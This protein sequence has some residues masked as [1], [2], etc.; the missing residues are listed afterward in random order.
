MAP[1]SHANVVNP[2][3]QTEN[4]GTFGARTIP[5]ISAI[6]PTYNRRALL[7]NAVASILAQSVAVCEII[8]VDDGST[9]GTREWVKE[10]ALRTPS[11][12][13]IEQEHGGANRARNAGARAA[14]GDLLA[15]LDSDDCWE[16]EKLC[17]QLARLADDPGAIGVFTGLRLVG[18]Q[19][20]RVFLPKDKPSLLDLR[21]SN[22]LSSTSTAMVRADTLRDIGGFDETLPSCQDWDLWF[23]LR[24]KGDLVVVREALVRFGAGANDRISFNADKV[25]AGHAAIFERLKAGVHDPAASKAIAA[26]HRFVLAENHLRHGKPAAA[27]RLALEGLLKRPGRW[28][29]RLAIKSAWRVVTGALG[30]SLRTG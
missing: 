9:D 22:V 14:Q 16:P 3:F 25:A 29:L 23:R 10:C 7:P 15:F 27:A 2:S 11:L 24:Q 26:S 12:K 1:T 20:K 30:P 18:G 5:R 4:P 13:L 8:I 17:R 28:G 19:R 21:C 6:I